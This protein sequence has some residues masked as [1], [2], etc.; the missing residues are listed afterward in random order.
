MTASYEESGAGQRWAGAWGPEIA[1]HERIFRRAMAVSGRA[2]ALECIAGEVFPVIPHQATWIATLDHE[3]GEMRLNACWP[4]ELKAA[5]LPPALPFGAHLAQAALGTASRVY[6]GGAAPAEPYDEALLAIGMPA[7]ITLGLCSGDGPPELVTFASPPPVKYGANQVAFAARLAPALSAA[8]SVSDHDRGVQCAPAWAGLDPVEIVD[9]LCHSVAHDVRNI[10]S[11]IIGAIELQRMET[12][13]S[14]SPVFDAVRRRALEGIAMVEAMRERLQTVV[15]MNTAPVDLSAV[16]RQIAQLTLPILASSGRGAVPSVTCSGM[17][18]PVLANEAE[19]RRAISALVFN[20]ARAAGPS[21]N[22]GLRTT[23]D[24]RRA[25][26]DVI[27]DGNETGEETMR[28]AKQHFFSTE[29]GGHLGLGLTIAEGV[30]RRFGGSLSIRANEDRGATASLVLPLYT[31]PIS[32]THE[33]ARPG[34][35]DDHVS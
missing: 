20:A 2:A 29:S 23:T 24:G 25:M 12:G 16:A 8:L 6:V 34:D 7:H 17:P 35:P 14:V 30:A 5:T 32:P 27:D 33:P 3:R 22:V 31:G 10:M 18:T 11:G 26:L 4:G 9:Y 19:L 21:G 28:R 13:D 1:L 15:D